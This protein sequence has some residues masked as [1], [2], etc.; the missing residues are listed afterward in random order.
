V[1]R[2]TGLED[3]LVHAALG[4]GELHLV[5]GRERPPLSSRLHAG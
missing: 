2:A 5:A 1:E 3:Y 4:I